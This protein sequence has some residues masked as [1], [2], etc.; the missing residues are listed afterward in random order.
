MPVKQKQRIIFI[1]IRP[2]FNQKALFTFTTANQFNVK[3]IYLIIGPSVSFE[4]VGQAENVSTYSLILLLQ[5]RNT[6]PFRKRISFFFLPCL[7]LLAS[8]LNLFS[9]LPI[10]VSH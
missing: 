2:T 4:D 3:K 1:L 7:I 8:F 6:C 10:Y 9:L 5:C